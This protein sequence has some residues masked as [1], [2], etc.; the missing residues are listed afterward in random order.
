M[1]SAFSILAEV[2]DRLFQE[3]YQLCFERRAA[4]RAAQ[5]VDLQAGFEA[6]LIQQHLPHLSEDL[7]LFVFQQCHPIHL[8][9][10]QLNVIDI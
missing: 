7:D 5:R 10:Q 2:I 6:E 9:N 1:G 8:H 3:G 4:H